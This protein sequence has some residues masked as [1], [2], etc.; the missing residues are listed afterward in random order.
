MPADV[1]TARFGRGAWRTSRHSTRS[2]RFGIAVAVAVIAFCAL[3]ARL[4]IWPSQGMPA[5]VSAI[6]MLNGPGR[7]LGVVSRL[8]AQQRAPVLLISLGTPASGYRCPR[9]IPRV[10]LICFDPRP[11]TTQGEAEFIGRLARK[12]HWRSVAVV[13]IRPQAS[14][15]RLRVERCFSRH[16]YV[17]TA[18]VT[19]R[20]WP[21]QIAYEWAALIKALVIERSC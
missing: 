14:R 13:A 6:A 17:V 8:A 21:Y 9:A 10:T 19:L 5:R 2:G 3:T 1:G 4:F 16:L 15:A 18:P 7:T 11:A 12:Y 20:S